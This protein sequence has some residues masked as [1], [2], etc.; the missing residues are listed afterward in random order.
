MY[1]GYFTPTEEAIINWRMANPELDALLTLAII[2]I[3]IASS[4]FLYRHERKRE[5]ERMKAERA[6]RRARIKANGGL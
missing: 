3:F 6:A 4:I 5:N 2:T 1:T